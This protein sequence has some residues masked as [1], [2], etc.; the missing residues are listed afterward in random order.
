MPQGRRRGGHPQGLLREV[1]RELLQEVRQELLLGHRQEV[2]RGAHLGISKRI[3]GIV[4]PE[5]VE[6]NYIGTAVNCGFRGRVVTR[7]KRKCIDGV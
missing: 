1:R 5:L 7:G 6:G 3:S 4:V 2:R